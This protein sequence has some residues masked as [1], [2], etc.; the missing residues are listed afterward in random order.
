[1]STR[2]LKHSTNECVAS[3]IFIK[4]VLKLVGNLRP[5]LGIIFFLMISLQAQIKATNQPHFSHPSGALPRSQIFN[6]LLG[7]HTCELA[8]CFT[9]LTNHMQNTQVK[10]GGLIDIE[11]GC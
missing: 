1:V 6:K 7:S 10:V 4:L 8:N 5:L 3:F 11:F 9:T 2:D